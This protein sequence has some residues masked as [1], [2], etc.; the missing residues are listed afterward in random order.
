MPRSRDGQTFWQNERRET[1]V[2]SI[3]WFVYYNS[4]YRT[5]KR[6]F[7]F[8]PLVRGYRRDKNFGQSRPRSRLAE[9]FGYRGQN[10]R[11]LPPTITSRPTQYMTQ[12]RIKIYPY[13]LAF[14]LPQ[15]LF[16]ALA[17]FPE[18]EIFLEPSSY[19][20][21]GRNARGSRLEKLPRNAPGRGIYGSKIESCE[22]WLGDDGYLYV[23]VFLPYG[24]KRVKT[25]QTGTKTNRTMFSKTEEIG[26]GELGSRMGTHL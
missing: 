16:T 8:Y 14:A 6:S 7:V 10:T 22:Y 12:T 21:V 3:E 25:M 2:H 26:R 5:R 1:K 17:Q 19:E 24:R 9:T 11:N 20:K 23:A 15:E 18:K 4:N 13:P